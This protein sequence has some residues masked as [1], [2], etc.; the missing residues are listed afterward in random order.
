MQVSVETK[1]T[2]GRRLT[3]AVPADRFEQALTSRL[4]R[5]S[6]QVKVPGFR[7]GKTP[8]KVIEARYGEQVLQEVTGELIESTFREAIGQQGLIPVA[9]P[10]IER[11]S[12]ERGKDFAYTAEFE[13]YPEITKLD[14]KGQRIERPTSEITAEDIERSV[15]S[16]RRQRVNWQPVQR[17]AHDGD[18]LTIDFKGLVGGQPFEGGEA[19][20]YEFV[21]G[22]GGLMQGFEAGLAGAKAGEQRTLELEFPK[23]HPKPELA[24]NKVVFDCTIREVAE[25]QL[26]ELDE[27]FVRQLGVADGK[28]ETLR[29]RV[30][31]NLERELHERLRA[32]QRTRVLDALVGANTFDLPQSLLQ[33]E[34]AYVR[35]LHHALRGSRGAATGEISEESTAYEQTAR[36]RL[37]RSLILAEVIHANAIKASPE[38]VRARITEMAQEYEAPEEFVRACYANATRLRE[39]E[40][41]VVEEQATEY[42]L[43]TAEVS[44][45]PIAFQELA[46]LAGGSA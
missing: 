1:G 23:E 31:T 29:E 38:R 36:K 7:P 20:G 26:P 22:A 17:Q 33:A 21:L 45:K 14:L 3:V 6:K 4:Q 35:R 25:P 11:K 39:I 28:V 9:G 13:I 16:L 27:A 15:E 2:L 10:V 12:F 32:L 8:I 46:R 43:Q 24:G 41:A 19:T 18:R 37:T 44:D 40:A 42:L 34:I 30:R 5:L